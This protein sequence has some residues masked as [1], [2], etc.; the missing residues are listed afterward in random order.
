MSVPFVNGLY[1]ICLR[2]LCESTLVAMELEKWIWQMSEVMRGLESH[3]R[4]MVECQQPVDVVTADAA[5]GQHKATKK[6]ILAIPIDRIQDEANRMLEW[7]RSH[8]ETLLR[9]MGDIGSNEADASE[10]LREFEEFA[11][12]ASNVEVNITRVN[13]I[14]IR[15]RSTG[16]AQGRNK[17]MLIRRRHILVTAIAFFRAT[18]SVQLHSL[19]ALIAFKT[20]T[21]LV[22][23]WLEQHGDPYLRKNCGIGET[24]EQARTL[25]RNHSNF[26]MIARN[27]Y[28][29]A[30]KLF[31]ASKAIISSGKY[32]FMNK[33]KYGI[34][35]I[36]VAILFSFRILRFDLLNRSVVFHTHYNEMME[37]FDGMEHKYEGRTV[38]CDVAACERSK[39]EWLMESDGTAQVRIKQYKFIFYGFY[40]Y[41]SSLPQK[42]H[43]ELKRQGKWEGCVKKI[44]V[45]TVVIFKII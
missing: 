6:A 11:T 19:L 9:E 38:D 40:Y 33:V 13:A 39:E 14:A 10:R 15:L 45:F 34:F 12:T 4:A 2:H 16:G 44:Y 7:T 18:Q 17:D 37:W 8:C 30:S 5:I 1:S 21:R 28:S 3:R 32:I 42:L 27:T 23:E 35:M 29:N 25:K 36:Y 24:L 43:L 22:V 26:R 20:D 31:E 41:F